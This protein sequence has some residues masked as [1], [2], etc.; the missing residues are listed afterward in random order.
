MRKYM[1]G[2]KLYFLFLR[3]FKRIL[4]TSEVAFMIG[5]LKFDK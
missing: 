3:G 1:G 4:Y 5:F 2:L